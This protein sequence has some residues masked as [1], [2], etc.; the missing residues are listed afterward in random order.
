MRVVCLLIH[1]GEVYQIDERSEGNVGAVCHVAEDSG[2]VCSESHV[3]VRSDANTLG[4]T[5]TGPVFT[6]RPVSE[7]SRV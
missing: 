4:S 7:K 2:K 6:V 1:V 3:Q 5:T